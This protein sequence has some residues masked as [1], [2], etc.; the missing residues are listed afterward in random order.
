MK[1]KV[2]LLQN[3][4]IKFKGKIFHRGMGRVGQ[5]KC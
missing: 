1:I 3:Y 2:L 4:L 5:P